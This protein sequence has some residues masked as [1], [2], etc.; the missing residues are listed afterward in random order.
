VATLGLIHPDLSTAQIASAHWQSIHYYLQPGDNR[1]WE[2]NQKVLH[3]FLRGTLHQPKILFSLFSE[4]TDSPCF[5][6]CPEK[7]GECEKA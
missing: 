6:I 2:E 4:I 5:L 1:N 7:F 3:Y